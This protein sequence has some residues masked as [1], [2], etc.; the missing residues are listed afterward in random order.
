[1]YMELITGVLEMFHMVVATGCQQDHML[2]VIASTHCLL[3]EVGQETMETRKPPLKPSLLLVLALYLAIVCIDTLLE[4]RGDGFDVVAHHFKLLL[5]VLDFGVKVLDAEM[6]CLDIS[7]DV[8]YGPQGLLNVQRVLGQIVDRLLP[9]LSWTRIRSALVGPVIDGLFSRYL[10]RGLQ[11][12]QQE[13]LGCACGVDLLCASCAQSSWWPIGPD[14]ITCLPAARAVAV[15]ATQ[16]FP[17]HLWALAAPLAPV[18]VRI[19]TCLARFLTNH[20]ELLPEVYWQKIGVQG[21]GQHKFPDRSRSDHNAVGRYILPIYH[22][23]TCL[24]RGVHLGLAI[25]R[26]VMKLERKVSGA[27]TVYWLRI[28]IT[29]H[30]NVSTKK[31]E[32]L[33]GANGRNE[34][35][36]TIGT[37]DGNAALHWV[38]TASHEVYPN[39]WHEGWE[40]SAALGQNRIL[41]KNDAAAE[42]NRDKDE[43]KVLSP[44]LLMSYSCSEPSA[45]LLTFSYYPPPVLD[46]LGWKWAITGR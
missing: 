35:T 37:R 25:A 10:F 23:A 32:V 16:A 7:V 6:Y 42:V 30:G 33:P 5:D 41:C 15:E 46:R 29:V 24:R 43:I 11:D 38:R 3:R 22:G 36:Q 34:C 40:R 12:P 26:Q 39:G 8:V 21:W 1:M 28:F 45:P 14:D 19:F 18:K 44:H 31:R 13:P 9:H 17:G 2:F 27:Q 4:L 20:L